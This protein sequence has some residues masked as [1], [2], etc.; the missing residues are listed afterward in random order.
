MYNTQIWAEM[1]G[2]PL[3]GTRKTSF[4]Y[5]EGGRQTSV[6]MKNQKDVDRVEAFIKINDGKH[7][8]YCNVNPCVTGAFGKPKD[9]DIP[10]VMNLYIDVDPV[11]AR[12][13]RKHPATDAEIAD[14]PIDKIC[15]AVNRKC[16]TWIYVDPTGNGYRII[17]P[18]HDAIPADQRA[19][20]HHIHALFPEFI[21]TQVVDPSRITGIPGTMNVKVETDERANRRRESFTGH[22]RLTADPPTYTDSELE[23]ISAT[24][25]PTPS[26]RSGAK[27]RRTRTTG[28]KPHVIEGT[29]QQLLNRYIL[30]CSHRAPWV[31]KLIES[32]PPE[33]NGFNYDGF[34]AAEVY[35]KLGD[36]PRVYATIIKAMWGPA[37]I[38]RSTQRAWDDCV[39]SGVGVW[40]KHTVRQ[41][42]GNGIFGDE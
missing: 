26:K 7:Q 31:L 20:V 19:F 40:S 11:K 2:N 3:D 28:G 38:A 23:A 32:G 17:V 22:H 5:F 13:M 1:L 6:G 29:V 27:D 36:V 16:G 25:S 4:M 37:Y 42:F 10:E 41:K 24:M 14:I 35:N 34:F 33:G 30:T 18:V 9:T 39:N 21:D 12:G 8:L 15:N